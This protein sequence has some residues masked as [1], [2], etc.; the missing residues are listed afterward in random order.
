LTAEDD[1]G[2]WNLE[3][4]HYLGN[5]EIFLL[6]WR[7]LLRAV[8]KTIGD[9]SPARD[10][11]LTGM[12]A[13]QD[14]LLAAYGNVHGVIDNYMET[15]FSDVQKIQ[16]T[17]KKMMKMTV[18][19][20][21]EYPEKMMPLVRHHY[22]EKSK[23]FSSENITY[24]V[25]VIMCGCYNVETKN[26]IDALACGAVAFGLQASPM[27]YLTSRNLFDNELLVLTLLRT[28]LSLATSYS[29]FMEQTCNVE[30]KLIHVNR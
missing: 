19:P 27:E 21:H 13:N 17:V 29:N 25:R 20:N 4:N 28:A 5:I 8:Y 16:K 3:E 12:Y 1:V 22:S 2:V 11:I 15:I 18:I 7:T 23:L 14:Q 10:Y 24:Y 6:A 9:R 26:V 30:Y